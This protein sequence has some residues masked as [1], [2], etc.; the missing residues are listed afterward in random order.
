[1][2][3]YDPRVR[4]GEKKYRWISDNWSKKPRTNFVKKVRARKAFRNAYLPFKPAQTAKK[5]YGVKI[6]QAF[7]LTFKKVRT[8]Q[9]K[10]LH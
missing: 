4:F 10:D 7:K 8:I 6:K 5:T 1:M 9:Y 3:T 2:H